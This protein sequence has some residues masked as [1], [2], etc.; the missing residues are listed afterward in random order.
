MF[1]YR[2]GYHAGNHADVLKHLC[3]MLI[4][5][6]LASKAK[7]FTYIDTHSGAGCYN[8]GAGFST[9]TS[10]FVDGI[11]R[12]LNLSTQQPEIKRYQKLINQYRQKER[13]PGSPEIACTMLRAQDTMSLMEWHNQEIINLKKHMGRR[14]NVSIHHRDGFEGLIALSPPKPARG[15]V[16]IDPSYEVNDDYEA[17]IHTLEKS[18]RKW[19]TGIYMLW[20][21]LL[22][23][24]RDK[25]GAMVN[26]IGKGPYS[27]V[28]NI[29]LSVKP[30]EEELGM[31][32][33]GILVINA[34]WQFDHQVEALLP[35]LTTCLAIEG[36]GRG[37]VD[38]LKIPDNQ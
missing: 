38:W 12:L 8:L 4:L 16:M 18:Y 20:Y 34:P 22:A 2:H 23:K 28:L 17:V 1:S 29:Q 15:L 35:E 3:Q 6:K 36:K 13:Y 21:P 14:T 7:P 26:K 24:A 33:S 30:Q 9:K 5:E 19:K 25:S 11:D 37:T 27:S 31:H 32:G 10:E